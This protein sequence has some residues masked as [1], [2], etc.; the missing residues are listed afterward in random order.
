[1][2]AHDIR[3]AELEQERDA[4]R[5]ALSVYEEERDAARAALV[6]VT[7]STVIEP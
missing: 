3:V 7:A 2:H 1:M 6:D 4:A 5:A